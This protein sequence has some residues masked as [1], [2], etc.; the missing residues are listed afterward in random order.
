MPACLCR[1]LTCTCA[2]PPG[3][4]CPDKSRSLPASLHT[5]KVMFTSTSHANLQ[6]RATH[7]PPPPCHSARRGGAPCIATAEKHGSPCLQQTRGRCQ[8]VA[9]GSVSLGLP[10]LLLALTVPVRQLLAL[11]RPC[12]LASEHQAGLPMDA[13]QGAVT[14]QDPLARPTYSHECAL[15][16]DRRDHNETPFTQKRG[17]LR[18]DATIQSRALQL[19]A[20]VVHHEPALPDLVHV[21]LPPARPMAV[22]VDSIVCSAGNWPRLHQ[23]Q[24][25]N[26]QHLFAAPGGQAWMAPAQGQPT[27][28]IQGGSSTALAP[29]SLPN[30]C[31]GGL[32]V[33]A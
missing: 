17:D 15:H 20:W 22:D 13:A 25:V 14:Q 6:A 24:Q 11:H 2:D 3:A 26:A 12:W 18:C 30:L 9:A 4:W 10:L 16:Q 29:P 19:L 5:A 27:C 21:A 8:A 23:A 33:Q 7:G 32:H 31:N 1:Q 28:M